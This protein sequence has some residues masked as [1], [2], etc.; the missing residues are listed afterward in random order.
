MVTIFA[1][2]SSSIPV[3]EALALD[4]EYLPQIIVFGEKTFRDDTEMDSKTFLDYLKA[5]P[6]LPKT[7]APPPAL[8]KPL[9]EKHLQ[10]GHEVIILTPSAQVSGTFRSAE[11]AAQEY[12]DG[13]IKILDTQ[14]IGA[15]FATIVLQ[16][17][18]WS[19]DGMSSDN[20]ILKVK[21]LISRER[22]L[23]VVDTLEYL[24]KGGR[25]G[26]AKMLFGSLLQ[27]KPILALKEGKV[28]PVESQRTK[29]KAISRLIQI[30]TVDCPKNKSSM[31]SI[32]HGDAQ[33]EAINLA[34]EFKNLLGID[35]IPIYNL[36][37]AFLVH[38]GPG[39]LG[40]SYFVEPT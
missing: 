35:N 34:N 23:F 18:Q 25:I 29:K 27:V 26:G 30:V 17:V 11:I 12:Q 31:L 39:V 3:N 28:E 9:L 15:S 7:S 24:Y 6:S 21:D 33:V 19:K 13:Q 36:P 20:I 22:N 2:T 8:Y 37:P 16:A 5:S 38:S 4:I 10:A 32:Q 14:N 1:D 40:V